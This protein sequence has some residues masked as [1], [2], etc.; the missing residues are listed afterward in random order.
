MESTPRTL[1]RLHIEAVWGVQLP[2]LTQKTVE[3]LR[4]GLQPPWKLYVADVA[5][6]QVAIWRPDVTASE[7]EA[8][9]VCA[10]EAFTAPP[11]EHV[12]PH[13]RREVAFHQ[14]ASPTMSVAAARQI[15][16]RLT[17]DDQALVDS[18]EPGEVAYYFQPDRRPLIGV[19]VEGRLLSLAHSSRRT[20]QACE[21]G[22]DTLPEARRK[23]YALAATLLWAAEVTQENLVPFYSASAE[24]I[25]SLGLALAAG[26][27]AFARAVL[28]EE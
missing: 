27:R 1:L 26:Y 18:F 6:E 14:V 7:R 28:I 25:A 21:L 11:T 9:L 2:P 13:I 10:K 16:C 5:G 12:A 23:G 15:A 19:I 24:N 20:A 3:L 8:L 4:E 17:L 22:I